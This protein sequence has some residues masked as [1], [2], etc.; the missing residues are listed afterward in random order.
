MQLLAVGKWS[1]AEKRWQTVIALRRPASTSG[2]PL[3]RPERRKVQIQRL[4]K[5]QER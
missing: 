3:S 5:N 1:N 4:G 2:T